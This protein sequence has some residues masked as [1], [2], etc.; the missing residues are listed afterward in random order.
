MEEGNGI[1][2]TGCF[3][4]IQ[5]FCLYWEENGRE[6]KHQHILEVRTKKTLDKDKLPKRVNLIITEIGVFVETIRI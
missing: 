5:P 1:Q 2:I 4:R 6:S 3:S